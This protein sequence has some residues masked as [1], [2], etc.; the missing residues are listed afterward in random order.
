MNVELKETTFRHTAVLM[1]RKIPN[2]FHNF[3][4]NI[5]RVLR[6]CFWDD[7]LAFP[8]LIIIFEII[9]KLILISLFGIGESYNIIF[10]IIYVNVLILLFIPELIKVFSLKIKTKLKSKKV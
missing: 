1:T 7:C 6:K 9:G 4:S 5:L 2:R 3:K 8:R 10:L